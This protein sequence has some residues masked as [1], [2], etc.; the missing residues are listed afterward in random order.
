MGWPPT[1]NWF[2]CWGRERRR[3]RIKG[4]LQ[5]CRTPPSLHDPC[6]GTYAGSMVGQVTQTQHAL[7]GH[8][9]WAVEQ[10]TWGGSH[11]QV[12][13]PG[14]G[15]WIKEAQ[16]CPGWGNGGCGQGQPSPWAPPE[17]AAMPHPWGPA[18]NR[19]LTNYFSGYSGGEW[20]PISCGPLSALLPSISSGIADVPPF[21]CAGPVT[22]IA[23][24]SQILTAPA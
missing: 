6:G 16:R 23:N 15:T 10:G 4:G 3:Q 14:Q 13:C 18:Y 5:P 7:G 24:L 21:S 11:M 17:N 22:D 8:A 12:S 20:V 2:I 1:G 9:S 19:Y